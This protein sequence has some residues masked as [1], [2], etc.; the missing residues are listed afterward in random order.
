M[1]LDS[2]NITLKT[3]IIWLM[4]IGLILETI[5]VAIDSIG[6]TLK[7]WL[8]LSISTYLELELLGFIGLVYWKRFR[9]IRFWCILYKCY[10]IGIW[11]TSTNGTFSSVVFDPNGLVS[12]LSIGAIGS[13]SLE[14]MLNGNT[15]DSGSTLIGSQSFPAQSQSI[16]AQVD[17][18]RF[19]PIQY[20]FYSIYIEP[21]SIFIEYMAIWMEYISLWS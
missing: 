6:F 13:L 5:D 19:H 8:I 9:S 18:D 17:F 16:L 21:I 14:S 4:S 2:M 15:N 11:S 1:S 3:W 20:Y 12:T 7:T 10:F